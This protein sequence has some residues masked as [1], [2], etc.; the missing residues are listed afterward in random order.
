MADMRELLRSNDAVVMSF[1]QAVLRDAGIACFLADQHM[2][3][4]EGS[5]G[6]FP[7]RLLV[8]G[9]VLP[10]ATRALREAGLQRW[11]VSDGEISI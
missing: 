7:K 9:D 4:A 10:A 8:D 5:I 6:A 3:I 1:A 11:L 2:S